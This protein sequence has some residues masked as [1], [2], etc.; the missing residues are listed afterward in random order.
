MEATVERQ[1]AVIDDLRERLRYIEMMA[2]CSDAMDA[3][4]L[5]HKIAEKAGGAFTEYET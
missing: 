5:L 3:R 4:K 1:G 2:L